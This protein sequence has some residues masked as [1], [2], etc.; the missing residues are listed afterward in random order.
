MSVIRWSLVVGLFVVMPSPFLLSPT[1]YILTPA[2]LLS[3]N[4]PLP[5]AD[6]FFAEVRSNLARS[7]REQYRYAYRERRS[8]VHT[9][10]FGK[11]GTD[12][13][14]L[15]QVDPGEELGLYYRRAIERDGKPLTNE[16]R[17]TIDR[18]GRSQTNPAVDD[19]VT[20]LTF[21]IVR[22]ETA[23]GR[24]LIVVTFTPKRDAKPRTR[25]GKMAKSFKGTIW[26]DEVAR[27]VVR[28]E[29]TAVDDLS[30]GGVLAR[31]R[32]GTSVKLVREQIDGTTW[33]PTSI[34]L[35][36]QG[37]ALLVRKLDIDFVIEWFDY[38][39]GRN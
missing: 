35:L 8:E 27:E 17:E 18:R 10:P 2:V 37:R 30:Y 25:Q 1:S 22:R 36:G 20:T 11:I 33:L 21:E 38:K 31:L 12:G 9:N 24:D 23:G 29:A 14:V 19:V 4:R 7:D 34:R 26:I 3:Q 28:V 5:D 6:A 16:K 32:E 39:R 15:Y 13:S